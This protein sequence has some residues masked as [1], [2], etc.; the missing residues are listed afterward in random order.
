MKNILVFFAFCVLTT[1]FS[2][3]GQNHLSMKKSD[4]SDA[5][6]TG[7]ATTNELLKS[8][9]E[10]TSFRHKIL[11][12]NLANVNT[13]RYKAEEVAAPKEYADLTGKGK[14]M[15]SIKL[16]RTTDKHI[17]GGQDSAGKFAVHKLQDPYEIKPNGNNVSLAQQ[18]TK[19][20]QNQQ[21]YNAAVKGYAVMNSL[22]S[23]VLGK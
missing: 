9:L 17:G 19:V 18:M 2:A 13:P 15:R 10:L 20:S 22:V 8:Y 1:S 12:Q 6:D 16:V 21:D 11:S 23:A 5:A 4:T 7:K 14:A 3:Y